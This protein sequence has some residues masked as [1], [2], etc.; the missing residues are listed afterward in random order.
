MMKEMMLLLTLWLTLVMGCTKAEKPPGVVDVQ[1]GE[2]AGLLSNNEVIIIDI[3]TPG[4]W[5][6]GTVEGA[7]LINLQ[8]PSFLELIDPL[9]RNQT[10]LLY[11]RTG[12][13]SRMA[14]SIMQEVGFASILNY[15]GTQEEIL[16]ETH[17]LQKE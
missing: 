11:C 6:S 7:Q 9:D 13:R 4:E 10:Y 3:R 17:G 15:T 1:P 2:V 5:Q 12:N 14:A 8:D 16:R